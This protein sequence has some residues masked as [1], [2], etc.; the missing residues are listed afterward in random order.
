MKQIKFTGY[1]NYKAQ[2]FV[3]DDVKKPQGSVIIIHNIKESANYYADVCE[4]FNKNGYIACLMQLRLHEK[5]QDENN[6]KDENKDYFKD[7]VNDLHLIT[8][9]MSE[10]YDCPVFVIGV[11]FSAHL[12][13]RLLEICNMVNKVVLIGGGFNK[14]L[15]YKTIHPFSFGLHVISRKKDFAKLMEKIMF[16]PLTKNFEDKN[17]ITSNKLLFDKIKNSENFKKILPANYYHSFLSNITAKDKNLTNISANSK[18]LVLNGKLDPINKG[19]NVKNFVNEFKEFGLN[20][21][22]IIYDDAKQNLLLENNYEK[23]VLDIINFLKQK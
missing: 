17:Y 18:I 12:I 5:K 14:S 21:E 22:F 10:S 1:D 2:A 23:I 19:N 16:L 11:G 6:Q 3:Y 9:I 15:I 20:A 8:K 4:L 13:V 7:N